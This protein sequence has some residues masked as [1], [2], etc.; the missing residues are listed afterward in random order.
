MRSC[1]RFPGR[2]HQ[3]EWQF[4]GQE[5]STRVEG[6]DNRRLAGVGLL[7]NA[8]RTLFGMDARAS[9]I[10]RHP[11]AFLLALS[12]LPEPATGRRRTEALAT[13]GLCD[14]RA[15]ARTA[16]ARGHA[17]HAAHRRSFA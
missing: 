8:G 9:V 11:C 17:L 12:P 4:D 16:R 3:D 7:A 14:A 2:S 15:G 10:S 5:L 13:S 1:F 6:P